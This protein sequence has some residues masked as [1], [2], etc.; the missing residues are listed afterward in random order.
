M[1]ADLSSTA[2]APFPRPVSARAAAARVEAQHDAGLVR[3]FIA[4]DETAFNEIVQR[5]RHKLFAVALG[6]LRNRADAEEIAQDALIRAHRGLARFRG[7][8]SLSAW[9]YRITLNLSR[10]RY[11]YHFRR[12][13]H[14]TISLDCPVSD[15]S[16]ATFADLVAAED[17]GPS[18]QAAS[19][20]FSEIIASCMSRLGAPAREI[21][22]L[23]NSQNR[24]YAEIARETGIN[25]GTVKSRVARARASLR[26]LLAE[27]CPEFGQNARL[28]SWFDPVGS[29]AGQ[30]EA[31]CA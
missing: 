9:L 4:G 22:L 13:R 31:I 2:T 23:R 11:W 15:R 20:E 12:R 7:D 30:L 24:S 3:R 27:T 25:I 8:S 17:A 1:V 6:L 19:R 18:R 29:A 10:N 28:L 16:Q 26:V 5:Y 14:A 21:L